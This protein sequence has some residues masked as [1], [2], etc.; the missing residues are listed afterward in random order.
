MYIVAPRQRHRLNTSPLDTLIGK[1]SL[2]SRL[3]SN[4]TL[5]RLGVDTFTRSHNHTFTRSPVYPCISPFP[6]HVYS[7]HI[8]NPSSHITHHSSH[9][10]HITSHIA[11]RTITYHLSHIPHHTLHTSH[12]TYTYHIKVS[13]SKG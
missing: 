11:Y 1:I 2:M 7:T 9:I 6:S 4:A 8:T 12:L 3:E 5:T 10:T 13:K